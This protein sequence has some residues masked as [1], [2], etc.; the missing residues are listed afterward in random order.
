MYHHHPKRNNIFVFDSR[1]FFICSLHEFSIN[2]YC[3]FVKKNSFRQWT[4]FRNIFPVMILFASEQVCLFRLRRN[5]ILSFFSLVNENRLLLF[6]V[7]NH[8][9]K[10][11][12]E[13]NK[14]ATKNRKLIFAFPS[15]ANI[16]FSEIFFLFRSRE[17][18]KIPPI[19]PTL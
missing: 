5:P 18:E 14:P 9:T 12:R 13:K 19:F 4:K 17:N 6:V 10:Q 3:L 16:F 15:L 2:N 11:Q 1:L 8:I 7:V